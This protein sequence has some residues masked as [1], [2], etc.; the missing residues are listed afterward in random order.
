MTNTQAAL[1]ALTTAYDNL[2]PSN[3]EGVGAIL[4]L[5]LML[6]I[7]GSEITDES[8]RRKSE[9]TTAATEY[10]CLMCSTNIPDHT[11]NQCTNR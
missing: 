7:T 10:T 8:D 3:V 11:V 1:E 4:D 9:S 5:G 6:G 2:T